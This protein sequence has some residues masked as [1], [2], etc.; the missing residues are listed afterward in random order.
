MLSYEVGQVLPSFFSP[1]HELCRSSFT[2]AFFDLIYWIPTYETENIYRWQHAQLEY[3]VY[4]AN[5]IPFFLLT[6]PAENWSVD[7]SLNIYS[8][9]AELIAEWLTEKGNSLTML[10]CDCYSNILLDIR[11][12]QI[13][14][15]HARIIRE[16]LAEQKQAYTDAFQVQKM[17][18]NTMHA[19]STEDM[20]KKSTMYKL[21]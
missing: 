3:G 1:G 7:V 6:F 12:T 15:A 13:A 2:A 21:R 8:M 9:Q 18:E 4:I 5:H 11:K 10:L 20:I 19:M 16:T 17:I 14:P